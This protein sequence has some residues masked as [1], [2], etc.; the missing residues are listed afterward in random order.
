MKTRQITVVFQDCVLCGDKGRKKAKI[1]AQKGIILRKVGFTT[2]EGKELIH[3]AVFEHKIGSMPFYV[4]GDKFAQ[5]LTEL[6]EKP[7]VREN[8]PAKV[9]KAPKRKRKSTKK[10]KEAD[11][12]SVS[13]N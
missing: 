12:G 5:T 10:V 8:L 3:K 4:E 1:L 11:N 9:V 2:P 13:E 7:T 6:L